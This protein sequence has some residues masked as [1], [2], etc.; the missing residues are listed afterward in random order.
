MD[1]TEFLD[2]HHADLSPVERALALSAADDARAGAAE[3]REQSER[4]VAA[5]ERAEALMLAN[6]MGDDPLGGLRRARADFDAAD[7]VVRDLAGK[8]EKATARRDRALESVQFLSRRMDEITGL[9]QRSAPPD[10]LAPAREALKAHREYVQAS[11]AAWQAVQSGTPGRPPFARGGVAVRSEEEVTCPE[12][13]A[14]GADPQ[15]SFWIHHSD[16]DGNPL[17]V[18][19]DDADRAAGS[20]AESVISR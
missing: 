5:E 15:E 1:V 13:I 17:S 3:Q 19:N 20:Y 14:M 9:A 4:R 2:Q 8:L 6:R 10:M 16:A 18:P 7:D 11:R 12:C